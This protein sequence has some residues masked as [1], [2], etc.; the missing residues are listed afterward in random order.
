MIADLIVNGIAEIEP[1]STS[2][3]MDMLSY[4]C[5]SIYFQNFARRID[6]SS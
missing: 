3:L 2:Q 6:F 4:L 1:L 5:L